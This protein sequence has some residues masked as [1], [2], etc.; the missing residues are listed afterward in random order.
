M[1]V[2]LVD[3]VKHRHLSVALACLN[4]AQLVVNLVFDEFVLNRR[5]AAFVV[6]VLQLDVFH[7]GKAVLVQ[8]NLAFLIQT[9]T[10]DGLIV[11]AVV[12]LRFLFVVVDCAEVVS[13]LTLLASQVK[14]II[15]RFNQVVG[16]RSL[17]FVL[18]VAFFTLA[19]FFNFC[20]T[21]NGRLVAVVNRCAQ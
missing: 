2:V 3:A 13:T 10:A 11:C 16:C 21:L 20:R 1:L 7:D 17:G 5:W 15:Q 18:G 4:L 12:K 19:L 14:A 6:D 8:D 9:W